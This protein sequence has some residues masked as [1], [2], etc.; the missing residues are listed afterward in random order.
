MFLKSEEARQIKCTVY[1]SAK[2]LNSSSDL[3]KFC[4]YFSKSFQLLGDEVAQTPYRGSAPGPRW[5]TSAPTRMLLPPP[6]EEGG[7]FVVDGHRKKPKPIR[8]STLG[9]IRIFC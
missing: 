6:L 7:M 8:I 4:T 3:T 5:G 9:E 1:R 2:F